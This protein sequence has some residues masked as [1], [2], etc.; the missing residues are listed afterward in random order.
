MVSLNSQ[1]TSRMD[2]NIGLPRCLELT[3]I[4]PAEVLGFFLES[5]EIATSSVDGVAILGRLKTGYQCW[6]QDHM[7]HSRI[8]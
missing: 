1:G 5:S 6:N 2:F 3:T 4:E 7:D 8:P